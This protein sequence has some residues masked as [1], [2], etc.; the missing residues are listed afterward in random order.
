M[1]LL[2]GNSNLN[3]AKEISKLLK[4]KLT[5]TTIKKFADDEVF[6]E[7]NESVR[8]ED[9]FVLQS[10][11]RPVND[12][13]MEL[14]IIVDALK[15]ASVRRITA[16]IPYY[17][18]GRQDRKSS[19]RSPISAKLIADLLTTAGVHKVLTLD[20]HVRQIQGF[21]DI[22]VDNLF[23]TDDFN[24]YL[25]KQ[26]KHEDVLIVSPDVGAL[27]RARA[28][29]KQ[30]QCD[31]AVV[32]KRRDKA[33]ES[34]V[35]NI[36]GSARKKDC[37]IVDDIVDSGETLCNATQALFKNGAKSVMAFITHGVLSEGAI[38]RINQSNL[39]ELVITNSILNESKLSYCKKITVISV[40]PLFAEA[41]K[42]VADERS[43]SSL[44]EKNL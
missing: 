10:T 40:A 37:I 7:I 31:L 29:A 27:G 13:L 18:Y 33:G 19:S 6:V 3:L 41:I 21:F 25:K 15:R 16:V 2:A 9:V 38:K 44:L 11:S 14:L 8:G 1:K 30:L 32:D 23:A 43:V 42:R 39:K 36:I 24:K 17:G 20:L 12:N 28:L 26:H 22:P 35:M 34:E 5:H 4:L